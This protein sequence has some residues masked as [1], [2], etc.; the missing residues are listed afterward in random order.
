MSKIIKFEEE[1]SEGRKE[2]LLTHAKF[3][4]L[5]GHLEYLKMLEDTYSKEND[6][7]FMLN[8]HRDTLR[9]CIDILEGKRDKEFKK[10][11]ENAPF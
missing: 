8:K 6:P 2:S 10:S 5:K 1:L 9:H 7:S 4:A 11:I 3:G